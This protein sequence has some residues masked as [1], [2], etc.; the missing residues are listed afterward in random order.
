M[1]AMADPA[2]ADEAVSRLDL[3]ADGFRR[4]YA[5]ALPRVY[6]YLVRRCSV[7]VAEDLVQETFLAAVAELKR[8]RSVEAP[9]PWIFGI[10]RHK[11][12]DH[13]RRE[14]RRAAQSSFEPPA[15]VSPSGE[16]DGRALGALAAIPPAQRIALILRHADGLSVPEVAAELGRSVEAVESLLARGRVG[17]REAYAKGLT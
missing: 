17:F 1:L 5:V 13:Y 11:L 10:A 6:G 3:D 12:L 15:P 9:L 14:E 16:T 7:S 2:F 4:F 8:G